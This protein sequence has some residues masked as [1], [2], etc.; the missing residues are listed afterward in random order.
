MLT[1][2]AMNE[3]EIINKAIVIANGEGF[4][5]L[6]IAK[7]AREFNVKP[8]S[9]YKHIQSLNDIYDELGI[10]FMQE[11]I[12]IIHTNAFGLSGEMAI[13]EVCNSFRSYA[14][15]NPGLYQSMQIIHI[16][17]SPAYQEI[18]VSLIQLLSRV[19]EPY[20]QNQAKIHAIRFL[21]CILHG[22]ID[23]EVQNGFGLPEDIDTSFKLAP[24]FII[25]SIFVGLAYFFIWLDFFS[26][27]H[28]LL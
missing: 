21:R 17:R 2:L 3:S 14:L 25:L 26:P 11:I 12:Q 1:I 15:K 24:W 6:T 4:Q 23:L 10:I 13:R 28:I 22:F 18:A 16:K 7:L 5:A 8:P 20:V 19:I 27:L 9:L